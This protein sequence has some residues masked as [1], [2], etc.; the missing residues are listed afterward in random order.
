MMHHC[1]SRTYLQCYRSDTAD[2]CPANIRDLSVPVPHDETDSQGWSE[3][4]STGRF[5]LEESC[6]SGP[7]S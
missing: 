7:L 6:H 1:G 4:R 5:G 3:S 2:Y